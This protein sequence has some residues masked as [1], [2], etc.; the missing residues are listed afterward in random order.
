MKTHFQNSNQATQVGRRLR[1]CWRDDT[2]SA[3]VEAV[4]IIPALAAIYCACFVWF[5]AF[6]HNT[7]SMKATYT[8]SDILSRQE[9][10]DDEFLGRMNELVDF[11]IPSYANRKLRV[12]VVYFNDDIENG[13]QYRLQWSYADN[14]MEEITQE[15][16]DLDTTWIPV[17]ADDDTVVVTETRI[18]YQPLFN[19]GWKD[20][21]VWHNTMVTRPRFWPTLI[22][23]DR[24]PP[25]DEI[26]DVDDEGDPV[27]TGL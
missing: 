11:L 23:T 16:L 6:R 18:L 3:A 20:Q 24:P 25:A 12:S 2:G 4:L 13:N 21:T 9:A 27:L 14:G 1:R 19:V 15:D 7:L 22:N 5:D 26:N 17:M 10:V 8:V